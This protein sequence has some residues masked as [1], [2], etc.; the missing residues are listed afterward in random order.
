MEE[1]EVTPHIKDIIANIDVSDFDVTPYTDPNVIRPLP[2]QNEFLLSHHN[3]MITFYGGSAGSAK[4]MGLL[5]DVFQHISDPN[6]DGIVFRKTSTQLRGSGGVFTKASALYKKIG[7]EVKQSQMRIDF[8]SG[9]T[10][11]YSYLDT[12]KDVYNHQGLEYSGRYAPSHSNVC[13]I[14]PLIAGTLRDLS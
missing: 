3:V 5:Y 9:A 2:K 8:P 10:C 4:T 1:Q 14:T 6:W 7:A 11:R 12:D 13:R